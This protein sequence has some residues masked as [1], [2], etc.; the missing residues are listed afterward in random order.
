MLLPPVLVFCV[1]CALGIMGVALGADKLEAD[2]RARAESTALDWVSAA[3][4]ACMHL[5]STGIAAVVVAV[6]ASQHQHQM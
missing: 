3:L 5:C 4:Q 6:S 1:L 2:E